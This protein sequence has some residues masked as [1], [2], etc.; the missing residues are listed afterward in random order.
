MPTIKS[1]IDEIRE[2]AKQTFSERKVSPK[3]TKGILKVGSLFWTQLKAL[4]LTVYFGIFAQLKKIL[5]L[6][7]VKM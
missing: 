2:G 3:L 1:S 6:P 4:F 5:P 7:A